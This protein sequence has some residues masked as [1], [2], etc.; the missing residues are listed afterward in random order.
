MEG[1]AALSE[2]Y[3]LTH[4]LIFC[5]IGTVMMVVP[6]L[7]ELSIPPRI[8]LMFALMLSFVV[9]PV[10]MQQWMQMPATPVEL[11][12]L[13]AHELVIGLFIGL[14][15]RVLFLALELVGEVYA[16]QLGLSN[17]TIFNPLA[18]HE[19]SPI[20]TFLALLVAVMIFVTDVHQYML[21]GIVKS[22]Q[23][24]HL[25]QNM[26]WDSE[27]LYKGF[28]QVL[29]HSFAIAIGLSAP[30]L[31]LGTAFYVAL[32]I[33]NRL[34]PQMMIFFIAQPAQLLI[35]FL[36]LLLSIHMTI[37]VFMEKY[38]AFWEDLVF[39]GAVK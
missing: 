25:E 29:S 11:A 9:T 18:G 16:Q 19:T 20:G 6:A 33:L 26:P 24:F 34:M 15:A 17:A 2:S 10:I 28:L 5:R 32:G 31:I 35:G 36:V 37:G 4:G 1:L 14:C 38:Q 7:S 8:K 13:L 30:I 39:S 22:Y 12:V 27:S 21:M 3:L 23:L